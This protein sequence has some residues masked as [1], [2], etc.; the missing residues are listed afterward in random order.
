MGYIDVSYQAV[1][2]ALSLVL[3]AVLC[4]MYDLMRVLHKTLVKGFF[5]VLVCD[6]LYFGLAAVVTFCFLV[7]RCEGSVRAFVLVG[8]IL[9][10]IAVR[11][12]LSRFV[13]SV[14]VWIFTVI[15]KIFKKF[16]LVVLSILRKLKNFLKKTLFYAKKGLQPKC[17]LLYNDLKVRIFRF[18]NKRRYES[19]SRDQKTG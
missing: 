12:T 18:K 7:I 17:K 8:Q 15:S 4:V 1:T 16:G 5:E 10:F 2:F 9:G 3:G 14:G 19:G 11:F 6:I 13:L